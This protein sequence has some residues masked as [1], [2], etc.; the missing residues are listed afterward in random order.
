MLS[1]SRCRGPLTPSSLPLGFLWLEQAPEGAT[2]PPRS[3]RVCPK[4]RCVTSSWTPCKV[5]RRIWVSAGSALPASILATKMCL[6]NWA[7]L[8]CSP[9]HKHSMAPCHPWDPN[10]S[11]AFKASGTWPGPVSPTTG[12]SAPGLQLLHCTSVLAAPDLSL[13]PALAYAVLSAVKMLSFCIH[14]T[15]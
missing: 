12:S 1:L 11:P 9:A 13:F 4:V 7:R 14:L 3:R 8:H 5:E 2:V 6:Q 15:N 10:R